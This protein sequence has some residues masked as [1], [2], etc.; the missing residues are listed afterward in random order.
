MLKEFLVYFEIQETL[1]Y[2]I[3]NIL[4][5]IHVYFVYLIYLGIRL[6]LDKLT[7]DKTS[8][9]REVTRLCFIE[10]RPSLS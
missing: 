9:K 2:L 4:M 10:K 3:Y 7:D 6:Y 1:I 5:M 8:C